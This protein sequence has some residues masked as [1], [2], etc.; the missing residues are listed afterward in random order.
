M[1]STLQPPPRALRELDCLYL[2]PWVA[3]LLSPPT[4]KKFA[5]VRDC[6]G[7]GCQRQR[8]AL[9]APTLQ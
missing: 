2:P 3:A 4:G 1:P 5:M 7:Y 6:T 9:S 8:A